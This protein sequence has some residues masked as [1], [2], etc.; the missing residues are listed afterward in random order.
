[1]HYDVFK[2]SKTQTVIS[3]ETRSLHG[4]P[5]GL[6]HEHCWNVQERK[7]VERLILDVSERHGK[8]VCGC[9]L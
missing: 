7:V 9:I 3:L 4:L 6:N 2:L 1:M 5:F 8:H